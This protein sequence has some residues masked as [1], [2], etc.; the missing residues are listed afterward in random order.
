MNI[1]EKTPGLFPIAPAL[2][3]LLLSGCG[4]GGG[5]DSVA[6]TA[7]AGTSGTAT[8]V[9]SSVTS[10][11]AV[12]PPG[13]FNWTTA[14][15]SSGG[16]TLTRAAGGNLGGAVKVIVSSYTCQHPAVGALTNPMATDVFAG[17]PLTT[18]QAASTS[19]LISLGTLQ[20][21]ASTSSVLLQVVD[22]N[23]TLYSRVVSLS[24][25][26]SLNVAFPNVAPSS[27]NPGDAAYLDTCP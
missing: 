12:A 27:N 9:A 8:V 11:Q 17:Y 3:L 5:G 23:S 15:S 2:L 1:F 25:L 24:A 14:Q 22:G 7:V 19:A 20:L 18:Q 26:S 21:P 16:V 10:M 13:G 6:S 4:G